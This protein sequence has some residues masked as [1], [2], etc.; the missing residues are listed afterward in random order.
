MSAAVIR[1]AELPLGAVSF[2]QPFL[3]FDEKAP[4]SATQAP[5]THP[6]FGTRFRAPD[7]HTFWRTVASGRESGSNARKSAAEIER[8]SVR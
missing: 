3:E 1:P 5:P 7:C 6:F 2:T 8:F 4:I